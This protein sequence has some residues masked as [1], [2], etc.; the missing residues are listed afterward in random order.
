MKKLRR[1]RLTALLAGPRFNG[2]RQA[3]LRA[4]GLSK[5]R[6]T[7]LLNPFEPFGD[8]FQARTT[9]AFLRLLIATDQRVIKILLF[10]KKSLGLP[11]L[12]V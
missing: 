8:A 3:F 12:N 5:G 7:Q 6:L 1:L 10:L 9:R 4:T 2:D 11:A